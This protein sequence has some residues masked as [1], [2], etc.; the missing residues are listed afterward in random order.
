MPCHSS[1]SGLKNN[2]ETPYIVTIANAQGLAVHDP[3]LVSH[4]RHCIGDPAVLK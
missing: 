1:V 3:K 4:E 2:Q